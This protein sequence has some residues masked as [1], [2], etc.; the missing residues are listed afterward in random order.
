MSH[1]FG[2][3]SSRGQVKR[4]GAGFVFAIAGFVFAGS[5]VTQLDVRLTVKLHKSARHCDRYNM[6]PQHSQ[7]H[8]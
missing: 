8:N 4:H 7:L 5:C 1:T 6:V 2:C 3:R